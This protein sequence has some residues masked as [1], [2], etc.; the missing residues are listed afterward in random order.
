MPLHGEIVVI[1]RNGTDGT[2]FPLT[3]TSCLF[4][5]KA[6]CDI[7]IQLPHVSK[8]HCKVEVKDKER[9]FVTN[10]SSVNPT[11]LNGTIVKQ[12]VRLKHGDVITIIDRSFRFEKPLAQQGKRRSTGLDSETFKVFASNQPSDTNETVR[13]ETLLS[14]KTHRKSEG[15]IPKT[16]HSRRSLQISSSSEPR[17]DLSP[18]G[19]L[20][21]M[22]KSEVA[23]QK[24]NSKTPV[25]D[26]S[27]SPNVALKR[28]LQIRDRS[29]SPVAP[30]RNSRRSQ[31]SDS[32]TTRPKKVVVEPRSASA[33][34]V[35]E[36]SKSPLRS[37]RT[38]TKESS[39]EEA[40]Q[41]PEQTPKRSS[42]KR[43]SVSQEQ[44]APSVNGNVEKRS[45]RRPASAEQS[46]V[47][48]PVYSTPNNAKTPDSSP[49]R[50]SSPTVPEQPLLKNQENSPR[51]KSPTRGRL[52]ASQ[53][54]SPRGTPDKSPRGTPNKPSVTEEK[55]SEAEPRKSQRKR[56]SEELS[57]PEPPS[58]RKRVSFGGHLSPEL[59]DKRLP[60]NSPLK[61]GAMPARRSLSLHSPRT[62]IRKSF[63]LKQS[64][65]R[66]VLE[67]SKGSPVKPST[68][69]RASHS[70]SPARSSSVKRQVSKSPAKTSAIVKTPAKSPS[71]ARTSEKS[72][73]VRTPAK[74]T[75]VK[76]PSTTSTKISPVKKSP[77]LKSPV[78]KMPSPARRSP[79]A[80]TPS[81]ARRSPVAK[82]PSPARR[83]PVAKTPSPARRSPVA[84]TPSP[85]RRS[86]VAR[87]P[88]PARRS[89]VA[90]KP[91]PARRSPVARKPSPARRSPVA[92][93]PSPARRSPVARKPSPARRSPVAR[94][95]SPA[96]RSPVAR[97][98]SPARRSPVAR[99]PSP[100]RRSPVARK[101]SPARRSP[102]ARKPSPARR[103]PVGRKPSPARR[104][105]VG[106]KPSPARR[107]PVGRKPSPARRSPVGR[108]PSPARRSP[109]GRKPS[110]VVRTPSPAKRSP[111]ARTPTLSS[112]AT[113]YMKG[114][115]SVS[116]ID[117]PPQEVSSKLPISQTPKKARKSLSVKKT[118]RRSRKLE[119]FE[120]IRSKRRSGATEANLLVSR[121]WADVVK[122]G[123]AKSQ[124]KIN[125]PVQKVVASKKKLKHKT[126]MKKKKD[127]TST[128]HADSPATILVGRAHTRIINL[129]G[130]VPKVMRNQAVKLDA[131][132]NESFSGVAELMSTPENDKQRKSNRPEISKT[133]TPSPVVV[134]MSA[135]QTPEESG[136]MVVSPL[137][138]PNTTRRKQYNRDAVSRLLQNPS[139]PE[140]RKVGTDTFE[141]AEETSKSKKDKRTS[142]G[143]SGIKHIMRTPKHKGGPITDPHAIRKLLRT[144]KE[145]ESP[146][147]Y[148]RRSS[149]HDVLGIDKIVKTPKQM[150]TPVEDLIGG[151]RIMKTPK[152]K[153]E[154]SEDLA[155]V[156]RIMKTPKEKV[157]PVEDLVGIKRLMRTPKERGESVEDMIGIKRIMKTPKERGQPVEDLALHH[158]M[159]TPMENVQSTESTRPIEEIFGIR[160]LIKTPPKSSLIKKV[161]SKDPSSRSAKSLGNTSSPRGRGRSAKRLS[162]LVDTT[163]GNNSHVVLH[164]Q[165]VQVSVMQSNQEVKPTQE[166]GRPSTSKSMS[167]SEVRKEDLVSGGEV[168]SPRRRGRPSSA[169]KAPKESPSASD[170]VVTSPTQSGRAKVMIEKLKEAVPIA[171]G[172]VTSPAHKERPNTAAETPSEVT[173]PGRRGR[174]SSTAK[175]PKESVVSDVTSPSRRGRPS[176]TAEAPKES[177][178]TEVTSPSRRG[179]PSSTAEAPKE[180]VVS[181]VKSPSRRGRPSSTAGTPKESVVSEVTSPTRRGRPSSTAEAPKESVV[182]EVTSPR[183]RG[184]PSSTA[185]A[186]KESVVTEV[187]SPSR[188]GR[189]SSTAEAPKESVVS[190]VTS[191]SRRGRPSSTAGTPKESV[192]SDVTSPSRRGRPSSTAEAPKESVVTEVISPSRRGRPSSTAGAPKESVVSEV[193]S[194]SRR[195]RPSSTAGTPKES[196][197]SDVTTPSRRGRPSSTA[198]T[199]KESV[200]SDVTSPSR[201]GRPSSTAEA[202]KESVVTEVISPSRRGRPSSTAGAPKE[203][204]VSEVTSPSRRGRPSSTAGAPKESVVSEVTSP[205]RRGRPSSTAEAPK[206]SVVTEMTSPTRRG[207]PSSTAEAPKESVVSDVTSPSRRG[208]PSSTAEAPKESVV[209]EVTSPTRRG[210]PSST[211]EAPKES[212]VTEVTSPTR[213]G[214]PSSTAE[215]PKESVVSDVTSPSRRGRPRAEAPKESVV[216]EVTSPRRRGRPSSTAGAPKECPAVSDVATSPTSHRRFASKVLVPEES[217]PIADING[218]ADEVTSPRRRGRSSSTSGIPKES[219][220]AEVTSPTQRE[221]SKA[222]VEKSNHSVPIADDQVTSPTNKRRLGS[223]AEASKGKESM[224]GA[225]IEVTSPTH[226]KRSRTSARIA[227]E[228]VPLISPSRRGRPSTTTE[229]LEGSLPVSK[230]TVPTLRGRPKKS[231]AQVP[232]VSVPVAESKLT[233]PARKAKLNTPQQISE[234]SDSVN[235][236]T[237]P[238]RVGI[239][240]V[241][242]PVAEGKTRRGRQ[243][244][245]VE[246]PEMEVTRG[247]KSKSSAKTEPTIAVADE[248]QTTQTRRGRPKASLLVVAKESAPT[249]GRRT[250]DIADV[251]GECPPAIEEVTSQKRRGRLRKADAPKESVAVVEVTSSMEEANSKSTENGVS[252]VASPT[253]KGRS[254]NTEVPQ[255]T[256]VSDNVT[257]PKPRQKPETT[258]GELDLSQ[259]PSEDANEKTAKSTKRTARQNVKSSMQNAEELQTSQPEESTALLAETKT[260]LPPVRG[261]RKATQ[262][263]PLISEGIP[264]LSLENGQPEGLTIKTSPVS[265]RGGRRRTAEEHSNIKPDVTKPKTSRSR[266]QSKSKD[267]TEV[268]KEKTD[269][270]VPD[271]PVEIP[272]PK[273]PKRPTRQMSE[274]PVESQPKA[275]RGR[276]KK[277]KD[278]SPEANHLASSEI[279]V[280]ETEVP[281]KA[282]PARGR[283]KTAKGVKISDAHEQEK[284]SGAP[285]AR[286]QR[287]SRRN[288]S[289]YEDS[290]ASHEEQTKP[291]TSDDTDSTSVSLVENKTSD[292]DEP[293][294]SPEVKRSKNA[295]GKTEKKF[296]KQSKIKS[297]QWHPL[298]ATVVQNTTEAETVQDSEEVS[299]RGGR[300]KGK[301]RPDTSE[302]QVPA[303]R[304]R[305]GN[306]NQAESEEAPA[307]TNSGSLPDVTE[308]AP[309]KKGRKANV[310]EK[311]EYADVKS[312]SKSD[313]TEV[314]H[315]SRQQGRRGASSKGVDSES[316]EVSN[317]AEPSTSRRQRGAAISKT[318]SENESTQSPV[319]SKSQRGTS[320]K[321]KAEE[322]SAKS[323]RGVKRKL[324]N[325][326][327]KSERLE[328]PETTFQASESVLVETKNIA[329]GRGRKNQRNAKTQKGEAQE[330]LPEKPTVTPESPAKRRKMEA[331]AAQRKI[332]R[333]PTS[334]LENE[335]PPAASKT[336]TSTRSRK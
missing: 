300:S 240:K 91:S 95:P 226:S 310:Q 15:N 152:Q 26:K 313:S 236:V 333:Q 270:A 228:S 22:L 71:P 164:S 305:R 5:R 215:A 34:R 98:P 73:A 191:P 234:E 89:P 223:A 106:R 252:G 80:K 119:A 308:T 54:K 40:A 123:V 177:V 33:G 10:L 27:S 202:P 29:Q 324:P 176:S 298:L 44:V 185:E 260:Q 92:R 13:I 190:E 67:K 331:A 195:G 314:V 320:G 49:R 303:K 130:Y 62:V 17:N 7:R 43:H 284:G 315:T 245:K 135:M 256:P 61:K 64:L 45:P 291:S 118:P 290:D 141:L 192:V 173:S 88:S 206:E 140:L 277:S 282:V 160:N 76:S 335:K 319:K 170:T 279:V 25:K 154:P 101:P 306:V 139:S 128:G 292:T 180:S 37:P 263:E 21:E 318:P 194:P 302:L 153:G 38:S 14:S 210:R 183:H 182:T 267:L 158:L 221:R 241:S 3:A 74:K 186:P 253:R 274:A 163:S 35:P 107:S 246:L 268:V 120:L 75:P 151:R 155:G 56:R 273:S 235:E 231:R 296:A 295:R 82:T 133:K 281:Q 317:V 147:A 169:A 84:R 146:R 108:K 167:S 334:K 83:S 162:L 50:R 55:M 325:T 299:T 311:V 18:F 233:S 60:P 104:S 32:P 214:R 142:V 175:A 90:R 316:N 66:E 11:R 113:P 99:K 203:S 159:N 239:A 259:R 272:E 145:T 230:V 251:A 94:K 129:T 247:T 227:N 46:K 111:V 79:V 41:E 116:H 217:V 127:L 8:E 220:S 97:K 283:S 216:T 293:H 12:P 264:N 201:R 219:P 322:K 289:L 58:K 326:E 280:T 307:S 30:K 276:P 100:A 309:R 285:V 122:I 204:V 265:R 165:V 114:R 52:S 16:T 23:S 238:T 125:K 209:T 59:F 1:K 6:E 166:R 200:V 278:H 255:E 134:E 304:S 85:A 105:P 102:V 174:P 229:V 193:T 244:A 117:T 69:A 332:S 2:H 242:T 28:N 109:V 205:S 330:V 336:R 261:R 77:A 86:P 53:D 254:R 171:D 181:D 211:A 258:E 132:H 143:L 65:V 286:Q 224:S 187:T 275:S 156:K 257:S 150:S 250:K 287:S 51:V 232:E 199:P 213:R 288:Q 297:V 39:Q 93:K 149:N 172:K 225:V 138:S 9:V 189:P 36:A 78:A 19:E 81:P 243:K 321:D 131:A 103:S 47:M 63:G 96:R 207:R 136:E 70:S 218:G 48:A 157:Q 20:Y 208:R 323:T 31:S 271:E 124:K 110:P 198:G 327:A 144:P 115:F 161:L 87:K 329:A 68:P 137:D 112:P 196:V 4:G 197:V 269:S 168:T 121:T 249:R 294:S 328:E 57:L 188:R 178:V 42:T 184:R 72:P 222:A 148:S 24:E 179:R 126:P 312:T 301:I 262:K 248:L 212:V 237:S 266:V